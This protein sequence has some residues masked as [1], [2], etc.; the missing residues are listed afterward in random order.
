[1]KKTFNF[2]RRYW[3]HSPWYIFAYPFFA[4]SSR[5]VFPIRFF[6][7]QE[8]VDLLRRGKSLIRFGDGEIN[9]FIG[10][11]NPYQK[12][13]SRIESM[14]REILSHYRVDSPYM[15]SVSQPISLPNSELKKLGRFRVWQPFKIMFK[16]VFPHDVGYADTHQFYY[17]RFFESIIAPIFKDRQVVLVTRVE[18]IEKQRQND[19]FPWKEMIGVEAPPG[20]AIDAYH[21]LKEKLQEQL[22]SLS[23]QDVVLFFAV[24][25]AGKYLMYELSKDGW[26]CIDIGKRAEVMFTDESIEYLI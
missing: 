15:L 12:Y 21:T 1:M 17:D 25:P 13:D 22:E 4:F 9:F 26:Q 10:L 5:A 20:D 3:R 19:A 23:K 18:T 8:L 2:I 7:Q 6:S 11:G 14:L 24:G 16:F